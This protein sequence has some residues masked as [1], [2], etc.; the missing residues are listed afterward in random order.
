MLV[1]RR[2]NRARRTEPK[3]NNGKEKREWKSLV[4]KRAS[5]VGGCVPSWMWRPESYLRK[6]IA[7]G[8]EEKTA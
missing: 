4:H 2:T 6:E 3:Q 5:I 1:V 8:P 7:L